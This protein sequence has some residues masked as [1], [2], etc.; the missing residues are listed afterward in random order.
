[1]IDLTA[2]QVDALKEIINLGVGRAAGIMNEMV[3]SH[4]KL[5][6]PFIKIVGLRELHEEMMTL[7]N[8]RLSI[9]RLR[10]NG[11]IP[12]MASLVFPTDSVFK[13]ISILTEDDIDTSDLDELKI[14]T[15]SEVGNIVLNGVM[16]SIAN[17]LQQHLDYSI[18]SFREDTVD[19]ILAS[20]YDDADAVVLI[21]RTRFTIEELKLNGD[22]ILLFKMSSFEFL[23]QEIDAMIQEPKGK[24]N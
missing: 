1:M 12:G 18:P 3:Q 6:V 24:W 22:I 20:D 7:S 19:T 2:E 21:A 13:L 23:M 16:G 4:I 14:G 8:E 15:L 11:S 9:V 5:Q 10:F 17:L